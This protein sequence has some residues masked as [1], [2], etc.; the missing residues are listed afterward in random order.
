MS[1]WNAKTAHTHTNRNFAY[2]PN[3]RRMWENMILQ[4][5]NVILKRGV[6][7]RSCT[8]NFIYFIMHQRQYL[9]QIAKEW[10]C[11][12]KCAKANAGNRDDGT[13]SQNAKSFRL[14]DSL[15]KVLTSKFKTRARIH[16]NIHFHGLLH[17]IKGSMEMLVFSST[18]KREVN[19]NV[20]KLADIRRVIPLYVGSAVFFPLILRSNH[21]RKRTRKEKNAN[22]KFIA[23]R[24]WAL[25]VEFIIRIAV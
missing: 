10:M 14:C 2:R 25:C 1:E 17:R 3:N 4:K 16:M 5:G 19:E 9:T 23:L 8:V 15:R 24:F 13:F 20:R 12:C 7:K 18:K 6:N 11:V 21:K 22:K